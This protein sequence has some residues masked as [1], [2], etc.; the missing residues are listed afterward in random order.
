MEVS[1]YKLYVPILASYN[2]IAQLLK[3]QLF[4]YIKLEHT[5]KE[6]TN[7]VKKPNTQYYKINKYYYSKERMHTY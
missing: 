7:I 3:K 6:D 2:L 4:V 1:T 5:Y